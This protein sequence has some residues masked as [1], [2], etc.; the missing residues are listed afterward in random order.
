MACKKRT[1]GMPSLD[2]F[3]TDESGATAIEYGLFAALIG[4][5]IVGTVVTLGQQTNVGFTTVSGALT[6]AGIA[7]PV[8]AD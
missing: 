5:V 4:A 1:L 7:A 2:K 8:A 3:V 6:D